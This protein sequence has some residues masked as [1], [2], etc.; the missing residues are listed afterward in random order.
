[1]L[2]SI[3]R[4]RPTTRGKKNETP[5]VGHQ[6]DLDEG[7]REPRALGGEAEVAGEGEAHPRTVER[8]VQSTDHGLLHRGD[9]RDRPAV[10]PAEVLAKVRALPVLPAQVLA[11]QVR[12][13]GEP[14]ALAPQHD[15][16]DLVVGCGAIQRVVELL[17]DPAVNGVELLRTVQGDGRYAVVFLVE[18][19][20]VHVAPP[21]S[22]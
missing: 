17:V 21:Y 20:L 19:G 8:A 2:I 5:S 3:A 7:Y 1:M 15:A 12:P 18:D 13:G 9:L 16:A 10:G 6:P 22:K 14:P 11:L 4:P